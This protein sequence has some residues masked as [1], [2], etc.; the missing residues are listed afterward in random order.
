[1][2]HVEEVENQPLMIRKAVEWI[3]ARKQD[4]PFLLYFPMCPP[5]TPVVPSPEYAGKSGAQ[6]LVK[7]NPE[8][9]DCVFQGDAMLGEL[10]ALNRWT[11]ETARLLALQCERL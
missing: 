4:E 3:G 6:D 1:M 7:K 2:A 5:H 9:G 10:M 11:S 8:Y